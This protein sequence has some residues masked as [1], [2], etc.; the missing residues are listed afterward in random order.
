MKEIDREKMVES[1]EASQTFSNQHFAYAFFLRLAVYALVYIG[2]ALWALA[3][4]I[5]AE[6]RYTNG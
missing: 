3:S 6:R 5:K 4:E 1:L 2:D